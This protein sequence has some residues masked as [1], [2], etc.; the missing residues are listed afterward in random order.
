MKIPNP[1]PGAECSPFFTARELPSY[2]RGRTLLMSAHTGAGTDRQAST[3]CE[4]TY[5]HLQSLRAS[6]AQP[7][8]FTRSQA[9]R[10]EAM[11]NGLFPTHR[12]LASGHS[13]VV[14]SKS[15]MRST[16][17]KHLRPL[18]RVRPN[19]PIAGN[20]RESLTSRLALKPDPDFVNLFTSAR[21]AERCRSVKGWY[22]NSHRNPGR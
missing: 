1:L 7:M 12:S 11:K 16:V 13:A 18:V 15:T 14:G 3:L 5:Y 20:H 4:T 19:N 2:I 10:N 8:R 6:A 9:G 22:K 21:I 17:V